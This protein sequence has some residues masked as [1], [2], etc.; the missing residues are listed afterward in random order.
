MVEFHDGILCGKEK[1][2]RWSNVTTCTNL[3]NV[4]QKSCKFWKN[5]NGQIH[6]TEG[7]LVVAGAAGRATLGVIISWTSDI[8]AP[9]PINSAQR[10]RMFLYDLPY[11]WRFITEIGLHDHE[12]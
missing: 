10:K 5:T 2:K 3:S 4:Q 8:L 9:P 11:M 7:S 6:E 12:G 1:H